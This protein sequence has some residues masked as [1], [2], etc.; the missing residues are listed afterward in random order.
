MSTTNTDA[1]EVN[2]VRKFNRRIRATLI[3]LA[4]LEAALMAVMVYSWI[5]K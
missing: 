2:E 1:N 5:R 3:I 4:V